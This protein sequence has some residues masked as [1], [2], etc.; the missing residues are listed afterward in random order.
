VCKLW[1]LRFG[2]LIAAAGLLGFAGAPVARANAGFGTQNPALPVSVSL[3]ANAANSERATLGDSVGVTVVVPNE[4]FLP[5]RVDVKAVLLYP[6]GR[7]ETLSR[8]V[9]LFGGQ[10]YVF[11]KTYVIDRTFEKGTYTLTV[12]AIDGGKEVSKGTATMTVSY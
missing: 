7:S 1:M 2:A 3:T 9:L 12:Q 8:E 4:R 6:S 11:F 5:R 10:S